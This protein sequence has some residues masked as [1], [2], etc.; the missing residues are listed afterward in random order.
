MERQADEQAD[1]EGN[2]SKDRL[3]SAESTNDK[4]SNR[5]VNFKQAAVR[6]QKKLSVHV[7]VL[8][9]RSFFLNDTNMCKLDLVT[10]RQIDRHAA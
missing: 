5:T 8:Q 10:H 1:V 2:I 6:A 4:L 7:Q 3:Q 9:A